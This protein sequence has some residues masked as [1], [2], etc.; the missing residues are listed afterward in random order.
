MNKFGGGNVTLL[1]L[2]PTDRPDKPD[3]V[4]GCTFGCLT[5]RTVIKA[6]EGALATRET[7]ATATGR[8]LA[9]HYLELLRSDIVPE[10]QPEIDQFLAEFYVDQNKQA[11]RLIRNRLP[12]ERDEHHLALAEAVCQRLTGEF[13]EPW[14]LALRPD[15]YVRLF[16]PSWS[17]VFG[18][19]ERERVVG[20]TA[21]AE[22]VTHYPRV[23][24]RLAIDA[25]D[26][27]DG[28]WQYTA[29]L[30]LNTTGNPQIGR[31]IRAAIK[32]RLREEQHDR[33]QITVVLKQTSKL[34][35][36]GDGTVPDEVVKWFSE[37]IAP[38]ARLLKEHTNPK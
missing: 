14:Q 10:P 15:R 3:E 17:T 19:A 4:K 27:D 6:L 1:L 36:I 35:G 11:W 8:E 21:Q 24:F 18:K 31:S 38:M 30:R 28:R 7:V 26:D 20:L 32:S 33:D 23:H 37:H 25:P 2:A 34:R 12:S 29:K 16:Q 22:A 13:Q 5:Y 9:R